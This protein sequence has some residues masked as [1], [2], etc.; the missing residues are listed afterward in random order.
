MKYCLFIFLILG[1]GTALLLF[2]IP[3]HKSPEYHKW[4]SQ[5]QKDSSHQKLMVDYLNNPAF[6]FDGLELIE[7]GPGEA[8]YSR[9]GH[10]LLRFKGSGATP[11]EDLTMGFLADF[12]DHPYSR[13]KSIFGGYEV[14]PKLDQLKNF[15]ASYQSVEKRTMNFYPLTASDENRNKVL[16]IL[17]TWIKNPA[18]PGTYTFFFN[19]CV[20]L[21]NKLLFQSGIFTQ[22]IVDKGY[23]PYEVP[24]LLKGKP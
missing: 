8:Y 20:G 10:L 11:E 23:F 21:M 1:I 13:Y 17:R 24:P 14:L 12:S 7:V 5:R 6:K 16:D 22:E 3:D 2:P 15:Q 19:N 9:W 18:L 4:L